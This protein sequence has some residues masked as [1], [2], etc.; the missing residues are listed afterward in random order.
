MTVEELM[1]TLRTMPPSAPVDVQIKMNESFDGSIEE[2]YECREV[3]VESVV[4]ARGL[5]ILHLDE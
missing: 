1:E 5:C 2:L 3:A 4:Y